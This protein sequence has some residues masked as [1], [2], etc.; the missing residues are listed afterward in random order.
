[1]LRDKSPLSIREMYVKLDHN[2]RLDELEKHG[3]LGTYLLDSESATIPSFVY[4]R[5]YGVIVTEPAHH[6]LIMS[7]LAAW[8]Y[9]YERAE[10]LDQYA[11][12]NYTTASDMFLNIQ[13]TAYKSSVSPAVIAKSSN[14]L[15]DWEKNYLKNVK[16]LDL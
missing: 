6:A 12:L 4:D 10:D 11:R 13:G 14:H 5:R 2:A 1:M 9:G 7:L 3:S 16:Y 15:D 8:S